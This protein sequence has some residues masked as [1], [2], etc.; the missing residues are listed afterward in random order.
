VSRQAL[1]QKSLPQQKA[2]Q[3]HRRRRIY[4]HGTASQAGEDST[5][6][7]RRQA[8]AEGATSEAIQKNAGFQIYTPTQGQHRRYSTGKRS[9]QV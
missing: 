6:E 8:Q 4:E 3:R 7:G 9:R 1:L 2:L 5:Q